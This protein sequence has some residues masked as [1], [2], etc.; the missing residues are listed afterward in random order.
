[1]KDKPCRVLIV[2]AGS[3][4]VR[5]LEQAVQED[6]LQVFAAGGTAEEVLQR[7]RREQPEVVIVERPFPRGPRLELEQVLEVCPDSLVVLLDSR[8]GRARLC[9]GVSTSLDNE[10]G[11]K[12]ALRMRREHW[13]AL[14]ARWKEM[15]G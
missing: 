2:G 9:F 11:I 5:A 8:E 7:L 1:M 14:A 6:G 15:R 12:E 3:I 13:P 10:R 4:A